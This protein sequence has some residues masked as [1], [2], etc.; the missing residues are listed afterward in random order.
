VFIPVV[1]VVVKFAWAPILAGLGKARA[2]DPHEI[3]DAKRQ[4]EE[5][6]ALVRI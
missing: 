6:D 3:A 4:L 1:A 5:A 2:C